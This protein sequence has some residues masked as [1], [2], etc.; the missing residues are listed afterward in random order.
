MPS[1]MLAGRL[2]A[3][4]FGTSSALLRS[5]TPQRVLTDALTRSDA[6][7]TTRL[8]R[9][10][11]SLANT[12]RTT[13]ARTPL[14]PQ[15]RQLWSRQQ[16]GR[17]SAGQQQQSR[18][19][20]YRYQRFGSGEKWY[21][22]GMLRRWASRPTFY[23]EIGGVGVAV[24]GFYVYNL[25]EVGVSGR[26][27]F[28][29]VSPEMEK[30]IASGAFDELRQQYKNQ[31]VT[32]HHPVVWK[33]QRILDRLI[34]V[35]GVEQDW[36]LTVVNSPEANAMVLP[37]GKVFVFTGIL[38]VAD[39]EDRMA[40]VLGH[41]IAHNVAHHTAENLS[42]SV[43]IMLGAFSL[44][45]VGV[46]LLHS[47]WL[48]QLVVGLPGSRRQESEADYIGLMMMARARYRPTGA[49]E[50]WQRMQ[51]LQKYSPPQF[52]STHPSSHNR[53]EKIREWLPEAEQKYQ[54]AVE[55]YKANHLSLPRITW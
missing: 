54:E 29:I 55:E 20:R 40:A 13:W 36:E 42:R 28:N 15:C 6:T 16:R 44:L 35:S 48:L 8:S 27:R 52:I 26:R 3:R 34:P 4:L 37:G 25:E 49:L 30:E 11:F 19:Y 50:M 39:T 51:Q 24:G 10:R 21:H 2:A 1:T 5:C 7:P 12:S 31:I 43:F 53:E 33:I 45:F 22:E 14:Q 9:R 32:S 17:R 38:N 41:E 46:D 47:R 23:M 18:G